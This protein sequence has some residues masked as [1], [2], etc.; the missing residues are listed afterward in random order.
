M[1]KKSIVEKL[2]RLNERVWQVVMADGVVSEDEK[3]I[4]AKTKISIE[5]LKQVV[6]SSSDENIKSGILENIIDK[7][8]D[9]ALSAAEFDDYISEDE[10]GILGVLFDS[11]KDITDIS[12]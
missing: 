3:N 1:P 9:D 11:L 12:K 5:L 4:L 7:I 10:M 6:D 2:N 8:E